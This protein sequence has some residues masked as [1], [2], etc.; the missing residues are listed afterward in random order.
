MNNKGFTQ[1]PI[2]IGIVIIVIIVVAAAGSILQKSEESTEINSKNSVVEQGELALEKDILIEKQELPIEKSE[3]KEKPKEE[4][5]AK[6]PLKEQ[7][8]EPKIE[9]STTDIITRVVDG[10]T[11]DVLIAGETKDT[12]RLLGV[13]TPETYV[14]NK[15]NEY[16]AITD[17]ACLD[18]WG[19]KATE[20]AK[21]LLNNK[22]VS[23]SYDPT[24]GER[25]Y[26]GRL[27]AYIEIDGKDF[28]MLLLE[29]GYARVYTE[30]K[31]QKEDYY[32]T[33]QKKAETNNIGLWLC[34]G[35]KQE[36]LQQES[37]EGEIICSHNAYNCSD[38]TTQAEAQNVF[39]H[40]GG[41]S[42]DIHKLDRDNDGVVCE[43]L[44]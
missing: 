10:D 31:C 6:Q 44:P 13:D 34:G 38:F 36:S 41:D 28:G 40:C 22:K 8:P 17:L 26:Y 4:I 7:Q 29:N 37:Q 2:L 19:H 24:A 25:G 5:P 23:L 33:I 11:F 1:I 3:L 15:A 35:E 12:I 21:S 20:Y 27:L 43:S 18:E 32:L 39:E 14:K 42:N 16:D 30:G 9:S